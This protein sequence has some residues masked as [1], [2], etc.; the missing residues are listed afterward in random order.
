SRS[1]GPARAEPNTARPRV[2]NSR[3]AGQQT[4]A[5]IPGVRSGEWRRTG[6]PRA[7]GS[8]RARLTDSLNGVAG[9]FGEVLPTARGGPADVAG[10]ELFGV[11]AGVL[12]GPV[13]V[14]A[15]RIPVAQTGPAARLIWDVVL[16]VAACRWAA[17]ARPG[18]RGGPD[19]GRGP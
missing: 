10:G 18:A 2:P 15:G 19:L 14:A 12:L 11:P 4:G 3:A 7:R 1:T 9:G 5:S 6:P 8:H 17:A 16:E 13:V